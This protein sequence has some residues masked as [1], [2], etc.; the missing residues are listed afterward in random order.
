M[1]SDTEFSAEEQ[2]A[3]PAGE[4]PRQEHRFSEIDIAFGIPVAILFD[5]IALLEV[6]DPFLGAIEFWYYKKKGFKNSV[7][8]LNAGITVLVK[9]VP[10]LNWI[11][12]YLASF[13]VMV[14]IDRSPEAEKYLALTGKVVSLKSG[15]ASKAGPESGGP[16]PPELPERNEASVQATLA[17]GSAL[18]G[19]AISEEEI[20]EPS[21]FPRRTSSG[22]AVTERD[23]GMPE[24]DPL[25]TARESEL[26][27]PLVRNEFE[28]RRKRK[29]SEEP[30]MKEVKK[31]ES[32]DVDER[33]NTGGAE[34][35]RIRR[36]M[37]E[38]PLQ[39]ERGA[40]EDGGGEVVDLSKP[41]KAA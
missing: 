33:L 16:P 25:V 30:E 35:R 3:E 40:E 22:R 34:L 5:I 23:F 32:D 15:G 17:R 2:G 14:Y 13:F 9:L 20:D 36:S 39:G 19:E 8:G 31:D 6:T 7:A 29:E 37:E 11:P 1:P 24:E 28:E 27:E 4:K 38:L 12:W 41:K 18:P 10:F 21:G 26:E